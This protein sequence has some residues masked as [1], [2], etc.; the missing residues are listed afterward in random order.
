MESLPSST[1]FW[2]VVPNLIIVLLSLGRL[3]YSRRGDS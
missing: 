3:I 2:L 1:W